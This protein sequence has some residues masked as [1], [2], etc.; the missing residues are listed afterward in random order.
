VFEIV[1]KEVR[2]KMP[3]VQVSFEQS[4][5]I[6]AMHEESPRIFC[7]S[8]PGQIYYCKDFADLPVMNQFG[9][10]WHEFGHQI[11]YILKDEDHPILLQLPND[12]ELIADYLIE[13][14][15]NKRIF[16]SGDNKLQYVMEA[17]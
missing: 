11:H 4:P 15:F 3:D 9:I 1:Y 5:E 16:Y 10:M 7:G 14:M 6:E 13:M 2:N 8:L 17:T 12:D